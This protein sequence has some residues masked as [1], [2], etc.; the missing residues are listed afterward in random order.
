MFQNIL[1]LISTPT[2]NASHKGSLNKYEGN[3]NSW[4]VST[5]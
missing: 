5:V 4:L 3:Q 2:V 1:Y